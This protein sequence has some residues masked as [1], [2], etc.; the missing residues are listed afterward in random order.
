MKYN[1][2]VILLLHQIAAFC[3]T[4]LQNRY[5]PLLNSTIST[6]HRGLWEVFGTKGD[7][8]TEN[9]RKMRNVELHELEMG[10]M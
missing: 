9:W 5:T 1:L 8:V 6:P 4:F 10:G 3:S 7:A 2:R